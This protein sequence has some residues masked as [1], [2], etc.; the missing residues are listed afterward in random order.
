MN[1]LQTKFDIFAYVFCQ[2]VLSYVSPSFV[3]VWT[4]SD[5]TCIYILQYS[6][7]YILWTKRWCTYTYVEMFAWIRFLLIWLCSEWTEPKTT[8]HIVHLYFMLSWT[9][10]CFC[11]VRLSENVDGHFSH[12][13]FLIFN[14]S[15]G[16]LIGCSLSLLC[17][18]V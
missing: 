5:T 8:S 2:Y 10:I 7:A 9:L 12:S 13:S 11:K 3:F 18:N 1:L 14:C 16:A 4:L 15:V 6:D 17:K